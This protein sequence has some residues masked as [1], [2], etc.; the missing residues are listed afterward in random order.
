MIRQNLF[1]QLLNFIE[2]T[3]IAQ[4]LRIWMELTLIRLLRQTRVRIRPSR[5][6]L[7]RIRTHKLTLRK[8]SGSLPYFK[9]YCRH[10]QMQLFFLLTMNDLRVNVNELDVL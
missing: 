2:V 7:I 6:N 9:L 10:K 4:A 8:T 5:N 3:Q 1:I